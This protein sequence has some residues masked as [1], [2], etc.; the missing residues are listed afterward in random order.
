MVGP[1]PAA[2]LI[3]S[4]REHAPFDEMGTGSLHFL[5][6]RL[7]LAYYARGT[8]IIGP[9]SGKVE[10]F[11]IVKQG[12][13]RGTPAPGEGRAAADIVLGAGE[14]FPIGALIARRATA[15]SYRAETDTFCWEL[16]SADFRR[17]L[18]KSRRFHAF[19]TNY[20]ASL[21]DRSY[22]T[23][24]IEAAESSLDGAGM[25]APLR[26]VLSRT[27]V[28]CAPE[29]PVAE[30]LKTMHAKRVGSMIVVD[31]E[32]LPLGIFTMPDLLER[33]A[34]PQAPTT[35][36]ISAV[37]TPNPVCLE[38][39]ATLADAALAM[40]RHAI[41]HIVVTRDGRLSGVLSERDLFSLQRLG[42]R[43]T[44][45]RVRVADSTDELV[46]ACSEIR[47]VAHQLLAQGVGA[48]ALTAM[49]SALND[50]LTQRLLELA[51]VRHRMPGAW[52]WLALGSEGRMEQ[53]FATDQD[54]AL[55][56]VPEG[57]PE[58]AR[59]AFL[60]FADEVNRGLDACG[61][62]LCKG[63]VMARNPR[64]CLTPQEW[65]QVF[66]DWI[67]NNDGKALLNAS[68][69]FDFR[70]LAGDPRLA[71]TLREGV[72]EQTRA[73]RTFCRAMAE[74]ALQVRPPLGLLS[75][76]SA[77]E[78]D[79]KLLGARP[80]VDAARVLALGAGIGETGTAARLRAVSEPTAVEAF[81]Y[82]QSLRLKHG[83]RVHVSLLGKI[84]RRILK[85][86]FRQAALLQERLRLDYLL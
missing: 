25:L 28:S 20:L 29:T 40:A 74:T 76:F 12:S 52:C 46:Q 41:R 67:R 35:T 26:T 86:A 19:C 80:I 23:L 48:E 36:P 60:R 32:R 58:A 1:P 75:D 59:Q 8:Q 47:R 53:T 18:E 9:D 54:N 38:E 34:L 7:R 73:N 65:R 17:L 22:R 82:I 56:F 62:P 44:S 30:V 49:V 5:A 57:D 45:E 85:E 61:F 3:A 2:A 11:Y 77:D 14:C 68:I 64:W 71:G 51:A 4:L 69:F 83:N 6:E 15:Y 72:L 50:V 31:A 43:R 13:V 39:E 78:I 37:M 55:M 10:T 84:D 21:V 70:A 16:A 66:D 81:H 27:P 79:L 63:D 33:V 24:R 42:L